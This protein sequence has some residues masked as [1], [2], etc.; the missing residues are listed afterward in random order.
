[1]D[2]HTR[3]L[4][5]TVQQIAPIVVR[6]EGNSFGVTDA[7]GKRLVLP[8]EHFKNWDVRLMFIVLEMLP[9]SQD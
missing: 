5:R 7:L 8:T 9:H 3:E 1:M 2:T 4:I 6:G